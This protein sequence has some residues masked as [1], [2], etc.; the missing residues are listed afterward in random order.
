LPNS[1]GL[2]VFHPHNS[3][4]KTAKP[5]WIARLVLVAA[6]FV[7]VLIGFCA[8]AEVEAQVQFRDPYIPDT[9]TLG[10]HAD[11][12]PTG[13]RFALSPHLTSSQSVDLGVRQQGAPPQG[14]PPASHQLQATSPNVMPP[15]EK[16]ARTFND[17]LS[18]SFQSSGRSD[19]SNL[20]IIE[21]IEQYSDEN[22]AQQSSTDSKYF[23][24][25]PSSKRDVVVQRY[26][27]GKPQIEREVVQDANGNFV[28]DGFWRVLGHTGEHNV[29]AAGQYQMGVMHGQWSRQHTKDSSGMF[30]TPPFDKFEGPFVSTA[31]FNQGKL[32]GLWTLADAYERKILEIPYRRGVRHGTANWWFPSMNKMREA[33]FSQ[34]LLDGKLQEWD[35]Q[36]KLTR[37]DEFVKGQKIIRHVTYYRPKQKESENYYLDAKLKVDGEDNWWDAVPAPIV[38]T[39]VPQQHGPAM[40]WYDNGLPKMKGQ[41]GQGLRVGRFTW[42]HSNGNKQL[43]G[44]YEA[45][46][47]FG[48]WTWWHENGMKAIEG[49]YD[50]DSAVGIWRAWE[51]DGKI[52]SEEDLTSVPTSNEQSLDADREIQILDP[53]V[54]NHESLP[55]GIAQPIDDDDRE[56]DYAPS[57]L[58]SDDLEDI[59]PLKFENPDSAEDSRSISEEFGLLPDSLFEE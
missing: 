17:E 26:P 35:E 29:I 59:S 31:T 53:A 37:D 4:S 42:W 21:G 55:E 38:S 34:G 33:T 36:N 56:A 46:K 39:G 25:R 7:M 45:G 19:G 12:R 52:E 58:D 3:N 50:D 51:S 27:D 54:E 1:A 18:V 5:K 28:N 30:A 43:E 20:E 10:D 9:R 2:F 49:V 48:R 8:A 40:A 22:S 16:T 41:Y 11:R 6:S 57:L 14:T 13:Q 15:F 32:D 44:A 24:G 23:R 47:K